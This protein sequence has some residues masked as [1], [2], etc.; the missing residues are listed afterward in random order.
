MDIPIFQ[1][2]LAGKQEERGK[3]MASV[4]KDMVIGSLVCLMPDYHR[5]ARMVLFRFVSETF[6]NNESHSRSLD[7]NHNPHVSDDVTAGY[8]RNVSGL[9]DIC[10]RGSCNLAFPILGDHRL[11]V[12]RASS[13]FLK[14][15]SLRTPR[16][17]CSV[18]IIYETSFKITA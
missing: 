7:R 8:C 4:K 1:F 18:V 3:A 11:N 13:E 9:P 17:E 14:N 15:E 12:T 16:A 5:T 2:I 6:P 10:H